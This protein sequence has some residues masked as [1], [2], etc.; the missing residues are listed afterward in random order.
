MKL[1]GEAGPRLCAP[2]SVNLGHDPQGAVGGD[3]RALGIATR[4]LDQHMHLVLGAVQHVGGIKYGVAP[5]WAGP[6]VEIPEVGSFQ[7][8]AV[9]PDGDASAGDANVGQVQEV[10]ERGIILSVKCRHETF[11]GCYG[12]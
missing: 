4:E 8:V 5:V 12:F 11:D 2:T 10:Q 1:R 9:V 6:L 7:L 3:G